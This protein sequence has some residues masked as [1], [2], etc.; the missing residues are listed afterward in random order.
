[1]MI[2]FLCNIIIHKQNIDILLFLTVIG[3]KS[4]F[5]G[6]SKLVFLVLIIILHKWFITLLF[7]SMMILAT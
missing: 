2:K 4:I 5:L 3:L 6:S 7:F 1:M